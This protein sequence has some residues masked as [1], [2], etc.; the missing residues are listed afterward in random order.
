M[1]TKS[2]EKLLYEDITYKVRGACFEVWKNF[3]GA[4]KEKIIDR[5]LFKEL[6]N[7]G[8][9]VES[10]KRIDIYYKGDKIGAYIPDFLV[11]DTVLLEIKC[12]PYVTREDLR[13]FWLYLKGSNYS[14][15]LLVNFGSDK[16]DIRRRIYEKARFSDK[17]VSV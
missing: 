5:A 17:A 9:K 12:K 15:G 4:F 7:R 3:G 8:L 1:A 16:L 13:Q 14:L 11:N 6:K 2:G 10:Q